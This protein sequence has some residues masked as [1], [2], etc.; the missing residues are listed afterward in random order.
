MK[1]E[2]GHPQLTPHWTMGKTKGRYVRKPADAP[3]KTPKALK[4]AAALHANERRKL[5]KQLAALLQEREAWEL[6][7][8]EAAAEGAA[9]FAANE[10]V[11]ASTTAAREAALAEEK[12]RTL[13]F[14][15]PTGRGPSNAEL[16][17]A[18]DTRE[19][20]K[21]KPGELLNETQSRCILM[22]YSRCVEMGLRPETAVA[23]TAEF[24]RIGKQKIY[25]V[26][27]AML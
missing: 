15:G 1:G 23:H 2:D 4:T 13:E 16:A 6:R 11:L 22:V 17:Q 20:L 21:F 18:A 10:A 26:S 8:A 19:R 14:F 7:Q 9:S 24:L 25:D 27:T 5:A 3:A 12:A